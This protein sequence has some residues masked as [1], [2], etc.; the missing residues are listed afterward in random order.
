MHRVCGQE[1]HEVAQGV[2]GVGGGCAGADSGIHSA[3]HIFM[4]DLVQMV[5]TALVV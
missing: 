5:I 1:P 3:A 2:V 4:A